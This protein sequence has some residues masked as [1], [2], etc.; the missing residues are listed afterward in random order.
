MRIIAVIATGTLIQG[1]VQGH[2]KNLCNQDLLNIG[3][4][5]FVTKKRQSLSSHPGPGAIMTTAE[6]W[7]LG[8]SSFLKKGK[9]TQNLNPKT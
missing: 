5:L 2:A 4:F 9:I 6:Y 1:R 7:E 8:S 3:V